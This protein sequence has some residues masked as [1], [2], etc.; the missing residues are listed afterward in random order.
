MSRLLKCLVADESG[1]SATEY[2][3]LLSF[4][5][6]AVVLALTQFGNGMSSMFERLVNDMGTWVT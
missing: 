5:G 1:A 4:V 2:A 3:I 6:A